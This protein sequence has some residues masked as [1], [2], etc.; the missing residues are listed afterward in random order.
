MA[1]LVIDGNFLMVDTAGEN[2]PWNAT[3]VSI[4]FGAS[5]VF[6]K[7]NSEPDVQNAGL[8]NP[9]EI[10]MAAFTYG[11]V[12]YTTKTAIIG[13]LKDKIGS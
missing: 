7:Y 8:Q 3:W 2:Y 5:S 9:F 11:G 12:A 13:I 10:P 4:F 6:I 1:N